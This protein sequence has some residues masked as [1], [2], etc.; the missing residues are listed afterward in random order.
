M[1]EKKTTF[2]VWHKESE[3]LTLWK[4]DFTLVGKSAD[5]N[6]SLTQAVSLVCRW[7]RSLGACV[8]I[9][10]IKVH[11]NPFKLF[12][13]QETKDI[14]KSPLWF[15]RLRARDSREPGTKRYLIWEIDKVS[16]LGG[17][18]YHLFINTL[19]PIHFQLTDN[20]QVFYFNYS[21]AFEW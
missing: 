16:H 13:F 8:Q 6:H 12:V 18:T 4:W 9:Q 21:I 3:S 10:R 5:L 14:K 7:V 17:K 19:L 2:T 20:P 1:N 11:T 15:H